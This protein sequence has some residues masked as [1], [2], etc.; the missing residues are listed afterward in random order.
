MYI[1]YIYIDH[2]LIQHICPLTRDGRSIIQTNEKPP[3]ETSSR[4]QQEEQSSATSGTETERERQRGA[5]QFSHF[6]GHHIQN[7]Q[8]G[9]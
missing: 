8:N 7:D 5:G 4:M 6:S 1:S 2:L 9:I 3:E